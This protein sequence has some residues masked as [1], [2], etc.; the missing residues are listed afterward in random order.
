MLSIDLPF[1][2]DNIEVGFL[3]E[4][5]FFVYNINLCRIKT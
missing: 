2:S 5:Y 1:S 4:K 3:C